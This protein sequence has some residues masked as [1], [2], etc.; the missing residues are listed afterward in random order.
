[1]F[2]ESRRN[3]GAYKRLIYLK[4]VKTFVQKCEEHICSWYYDAVTEKRRK[5]IKVFTF[6]IANAQSLVNRGTINN[7]RIFRALFYHDIGGTSFYINKHNS[8]PV[9]YHNVE[10]AKLSCCI[11]RDSI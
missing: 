6:S 3:K 1:M 10:S 5:K 9:S 7:A 8:M 4:I 11:S 2:F